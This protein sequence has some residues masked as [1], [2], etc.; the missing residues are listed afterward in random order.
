MK[1]L[2]QVG[3]KECGDIAKLL[4]LRYPRAVI[5]SD[6]LK[7]TKAVIY[8]FLSPIISETT[9]ELNSIKKTNNT[10]KINSRSNSQ[11]H[12]EPLKSR[13]VGGMMSGRSTS[14]IKSNNVNHKT[15]TD[16]KIY[17]KLKVSDNTKKLKEL[18]KDGYYEDYGTSRMQQKE[19]SMKWEK[20][21]F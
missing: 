1:V 14:I 7:K 21:N 9:F 2:P 11:Y 17:P 15:G 4:K 12:V 5:L 13:A 16:S 8:E 19:K 10:R 6:A 3:E 20:G 18:A